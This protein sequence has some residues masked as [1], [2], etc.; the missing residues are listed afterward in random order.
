[1]NVGIYCDTNSSAAC[2]SPPTIRDT[3]ARSSVKICI[4]IKRL[5]RGRPRRLLNG[6]LKTRRAEFNTAS[7][8]QTIIFLPPTGNF[9]SGGDYT[10][11]REGEA[12][13]TD[14]V[15]CV[16]FSF[17]PV[18]AGGSCEARQAPPPDPRPSLVNTS[19]SQTWPVCNLTNRLAHN[20]APRKTRQSSAS[21]RWKAFS[22]VCKKIPGIRGHP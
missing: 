8:P 10:G 2:S 7:E 20:C 22:P 14:S 17:R 9:P 18:S 3:N 5:V 15:H 16:Q 4:G 12:R 21:T 11:G 19:D 1:M 6:N 13:Q